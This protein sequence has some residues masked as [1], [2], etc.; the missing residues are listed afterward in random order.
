MK[1]FHHQSGQATLELLVLL[2]GFVSLFLGLVFVCGLA[3]GD[4]GILL[5]ARNHAELAAA[6]SNPMTVGG[7]EFGNVNSGTHDIYEKDE[8]LIFSPK[9]YTGRSPNNTLKEFP[10]AFS[11]QQDSVLSDT[12]TDYKLQAEMKEWKN[13]RDAGNGFFRSDFVNSIDTGNGLSAARLVSAESSGAS[14]VTTVPCCGTNDFFSGLA[15]WFGISISCDSLQRASGNR[16][17]MPVF[18]KLD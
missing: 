13:F 18:S 10:A 7:A 1:K 15:K 14:C 6:G 4:I 2:I 11:S 9:D 17:Y 3:D 12:H 8:R 16:V 5:K